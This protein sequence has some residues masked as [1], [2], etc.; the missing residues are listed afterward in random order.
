MT[1]T[2]MVKV[3]E[4]S[5]VPVAA[6]EGEI[7]LANAADCRAQLVAAVPN[8]APGL[9]VDLSH[10]TYL[11]SRGVHLILELA[12]RLRTSQQQ[13]ALLVPERSVI[14]RV[15]LLTQVDKTVP[16]YRTLD[17]ALKLFQT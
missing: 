14:R 10:T 7:D 6:P 11:D 13:L 15:L 8:T 1:V 17:E 2:A 9:I 3:L 12:E 16:F 5:G 4:R